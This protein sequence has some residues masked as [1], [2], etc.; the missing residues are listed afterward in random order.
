MNIR[1]AFRVLPKS[2]GSFINDIKPGVS[3]RRSGTSEFYHGDRV[4]STTKISNTSQTVTDTRV[5]D[6]FGMLLSS[7][8]SNPTPFGFVAKGGYQ[9]DPD[10]GLMLLGHRYYDPST[11]RFLSRDRAK[12]GRNWYDYC[13]NDPQRYSDPSGLDTWYSRTWDWIVDKA[14]S[15]ARGAVVVI[16]VITLVKPTVSFFAALWVAAKGSDER[17]RMNETYLKAKGISE[18]Q[19][20]DLIRSNSAPSVGDAGDVMGNWWN[21]SVSFYG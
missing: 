16:G 21:L 1:M 12:D 8:G 9:Q 15:G 7:T 20:I 19:R 11:G 14:G 10:T 2:P 4:G 17:I 5:Y 6:A 3:E 18:E 13:T